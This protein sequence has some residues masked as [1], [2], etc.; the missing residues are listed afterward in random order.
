MRIALFILLD[1]VGWRHAEQARFLAELCPY[2]QPLKTVL[3][4]SCA[5]VP[6]ILSGKLPVETR[7]WAMW[8]YSP[9]TSP[10]RQAAW[11]VKVPS[12]VRRLLRVTR[13]QV[14][15]D[16]KARRGITGYCEVYQI[17]D[18]LLPLMDT[19]IGKSL[20]LPKALSPVESIF[21]RWREDGVP[22]RVYG[23]PTPDRETLDLVAADLAQ[24]PCRAYFLHLYETDSYL[25][26]HCTEPTLVQARLTRYGED[27]A[28]LFRTAEAHG[29]PVDL[30]IFSDHGMT[31]VSGQYD[32]MR[33]IA[34]L[35]LTTGR[36]YV[37]FYDSSM[38]RFWFLR[39]T[40]ESRIRALLERLECGRVLPEDELVRLGICFPD[41]QFGQLIFLMRPGWVIN[42]SHMGSVPLNG[43][44][45]FHPLED[46]WADAILLSTRPI[47]APASH[48]AD[49]Y[50]LMCR[51][52]RPG[53]PYDPD[54]A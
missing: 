45:G 42:P 5:A 18:E 51:S 6:T 13:Q 38:A 1:G 50:Q 31:P 23:Y 43:M 2:R 54:R 25:H 28:T 33:D 26:G 9:E 44:H 40:A 46:P 49:L 12:P 35:R 22:Y 29:V 30:L 20:Y 39:P 37:P 19:C 7:Q 48:I 16:Y 32:L 15:G 41:R 8:F 36:D 11:L 21:D 53:G 27:I 3:G 52:I 34:Q 4:Y 47:P 17:P 10:F 24:D 14:I